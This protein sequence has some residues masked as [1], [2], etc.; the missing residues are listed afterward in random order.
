[1]LV[2]SLHNLAAADWPTHPVRI[3]APSTPGGAADTF[4][5]IIAEHLGEVFSQSFYVE[6]RPGAGGLIGAAATA[7]AEPDGYTLTT[8]AIAYQVLAPAV[9][10]TA[11]FDPMRDF[12][13]IAYIGGPPNVFVVNPDS[14]VHSIKD[15]IELARREGPISYVSPGVGTLGNLLAEY[16]AQKAGIKLQHIPTKGSSVAM[17]ELVSGR[18]K[19]GTM[20]WSSALGQ[21]RAGKVIPIAVSSKTRV[22]EFPDVPTLKELGYEDLVALTWFGLSGPAG[23]PK[24]ITRKL[25]EATIKIVG[26]P[27]VRE[28]FERD[29]I[30][31]DPMTSEEFT[32]F[33][34]SE[35]G[36]WAPIARQ[37]LH[38]K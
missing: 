30:E 28:R 22:K 7:H 14:G 16:F 13:H 8:S 31:A 34:A 33:V 26:L 29:A 38:P 35:I 32:Q 1:M 25:N 24:D 9:N 2:L 4:G 17:I 23:L 18:V 10:A 20:T 15:L 36:K 21:I 3:I 5:R 11:G 37:V 12:T 6:N 19:L 27:D